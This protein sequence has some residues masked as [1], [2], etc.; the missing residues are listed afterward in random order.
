MGKTTLDSSASSATVDRSTLGSTIEVVDPRTGTTSLQQ[1][2]ATAS[3]LP[4]SASRSSQASRESAARFSR[5]ERDTVKL[6]VQ[7][8]G[9]PTLRAKTV[10]EMR[11]ISKLLSGKYYVTEA[12][13][14]LSSA[15][16]VV[17]L[18]LTRDGHGQRAG[19]A[20]QGGQD[21]R[22]TPP[23]GGTLAPVEVIDPRTGGSHLEYRRD[24]R[25]LGSEDPEAAMSRLR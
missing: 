16:Y 12:K 20:A 10:V 15:G 17:D 14:V 1:R 21:N 18:K 25:V 13:H 2:N 7:V 5:A 11:G 8:V 3:V 4:T 24:G 6:A 23:V 22:S 9:D 19:A